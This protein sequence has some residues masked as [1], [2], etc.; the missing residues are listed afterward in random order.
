MNENIQ[1][2]R[3]RQKENLTQNNRTEYA[4][5]RQQ[6]REI[7]LNFFFLNP[8]STENKCLTIH[9]RETP[10]TYCIHDNIT[11]KFNQKQNVMNHPLIQRFHILLLKKNS[12]T[13]HKCQSRNTK[14]QSH[15]Y[16]TPP[17]GE[18]EFHRTGS[19]CTYQFNPE[20]NIS[21]GH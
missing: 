16:E 19:L 13:Q 3:S 2:K 5:K 10:T 15:C 12:S 20:H 14:I 11:N 17:H 8:N 1:K 9:E 7:I 18:S 21:I 4:T 6:S